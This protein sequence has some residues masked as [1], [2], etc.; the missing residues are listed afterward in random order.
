MTCEAGVYEFRYLNEKGQLVSADRCKRDKATVVLT[1]F[2]HHLPPV[3]S[4]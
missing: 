1:A 2:L 3:D 4:S